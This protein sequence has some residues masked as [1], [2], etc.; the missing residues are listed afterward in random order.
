V[1]VPRTKSREAYV[2][3]IPLRFDRSSFKKPVTTAARRPWG[4]GVVKVDEAACFVPGDVPR[5]PPGAD[6]LLTK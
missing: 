3:T 4:R 1:Q 2:V 6:G 5:S